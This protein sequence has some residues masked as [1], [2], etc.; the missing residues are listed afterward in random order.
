MNTEEAADF[1]IDIGALLDDDTY[2]PTAALE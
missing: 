2:M 1:D